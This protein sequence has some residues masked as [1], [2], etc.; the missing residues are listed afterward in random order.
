MVYGLSLGLSIASV[1]LFLAVKHLTASILEIPTGIFA[2]LYGRKCS[3]QVSYLLG[4]LGALVYYGTSNTTFLILGAVC[5]GAGFAFHSGAFEALVIDALDLA[6]DERRRNYLFSRISIASTVGTI[7]GGVLGSALAFWDMRAIWLGQG[8]GF[9]L[10]LLIITYCFPQSKHQQQT[11]S[12]RVM[13]S[14]RLHASGFFQIAKQHARMRQLF[15]VGLLIA[16]ATAIYGVTWPLVL[17]QLHLS[18]NLLGVVSSLAAVAYILGSLLIERLVR[19]MGV[20]GVIYI[21]LLLHALLLLVFVFSAQLFVGILMFVLI[22]GIQGGHGPILFS[23]LNRFLPSP[24]R[25]SFLS[26]FSLGESL[27]G[28]LGEALS[29]LLLTRYSTSLVIV[30]A[31][32]SMGCAA[33]GLWKGSG[34]DSG[35]S[36]PHSDADHG[37]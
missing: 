5:M 22:D 19:T 35:L 20:E 10:L 36:S 24:H 18:P 37:V 28:S 13:D 1:G 31:S 17:T 3:V 16:F 9:V 12:R 25:A 34:R 2:D 32:V 14:L 26:T 29:G 7:L 33:L 4:G 15:G 6:E 11:P 27:S 21:V 23:Y 30:I 8:A